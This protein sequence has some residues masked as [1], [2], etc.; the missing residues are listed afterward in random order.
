LKK[1]N[2]FGDICLDGI[3]WQRFEF[4]PALRTLMDGAVNVGNLEC[5]ITLHEVP[6]PLQVRNLRAPAESLTLLQGFAAV[7]LANNHVQDYGETGCRD[8]LA[9]LGQTG[10]GHF[11]LGP[12]QGSALTPL[13]LERDGVR[14][15]LLGATRYANAGDGLLGTASERP[16]RLRRVIRR[17][18]ADGCF[19]VT[20]FHWGYEY[21]H[22]P[23]P[24]ER[25]IAH[26]CIDAGADLVIG[27]H[28]HV[29]QACETYCG[30]QIYYSL[31]NFIFHSRVFDGL[32]PVPNDPRLQEGL[33]ISVQI[34]PNHQYDAAVHVVRL[35]DTSAR[36]LDAAGSAPILTQ[37][38]A[39][40][41]L[42]AGPRL[43]YLRAYFRQTP[44]I[45]RQNARIRKEYQMAVV[46]SWADLLK[47][48][49]RFNGQDVMNRLAA[50]VIGRQEQ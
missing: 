22:V 38:T 18:K 9:A 11:G 35:T 50:K 24:R 25:G 20:Y 17:L 43:P 13:I 12:D 1:V 30:R 47:V 8:T 2:F 46:A 33:V 32:S 7:S 15:A 16:S 40:A 37:M 27:S 3:D 6:K 44:A 29:W 34:R 36:L 26:A 21:V 49:R 39:L 10:I 42:L 45:A 48:Y 23:S 14:L 5:P 31:G 28:P 19:V 41:D 4:D